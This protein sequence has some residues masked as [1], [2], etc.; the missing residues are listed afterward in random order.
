MTTAIVRQIGAEFDRAHMIAI[1]SGFGAPC[2]VLLFFGILLAA[3]PTMAQGSDAATAET[4]FEQGRDLLRAGKAAE[5]CPKLA[6]SQRLDPANGTLLALALCHEADGKLASAWAEFVDVETRSRNDGRAD[7]EQVAHEHARLLRARLSTLEV[8]VPAGVALLAGL[9]IRR[10]GVTIGGGAWNSPLPVDGGQHTVEVSAAGKSTWQGTIIV[11]R[12]GDTKVISVPELL[13][14]PTASTTPVAPP[15]AN[16]N[17]AAPPEPH[18]SGWGVLEWAGVGTAGAGVIALGVGTYFLGSAL[19]LKSKSDTNCTGDV[20]GEIG[21]PDRSLAVSHGNTA[22]VLGIAGGALVAGGAGLFFL[23]RAR[24]SHR[25]S[26]ADGGLAL[27]L[28]PTGFGAG[29]STHF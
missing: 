18:H 26:P 1:Q 17:V 3:P 21:Y 5:A 7:R 14:A 29:Y 23:G 28:G 11:D 10:D 19:H 15:T 25:G 27:S 20:C 8:R 6:E 9:Q 4:M 2:C 16:K 24:A 22:T 13:E 12:E